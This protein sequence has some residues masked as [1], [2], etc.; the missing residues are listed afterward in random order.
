MSTLMM[1]GL[2]VGLAFILAVGL[3]SVAN[4]LRLRI[5]YPPLANPDG[6][7]EADETELANDSSPLPQSSSRS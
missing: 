3:F 6:D 2:F 1:V 7:E 4:D 5:E